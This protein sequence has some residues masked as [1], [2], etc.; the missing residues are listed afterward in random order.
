M[1]SNRQKE[2][3]CYR[4]IK[5]EEANGTQHIIMILK[6]SFYMQATVQCTNK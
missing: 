5:Q 6:N 2:K 3:E 1:G 4:K